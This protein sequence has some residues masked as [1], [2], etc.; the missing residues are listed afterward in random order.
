MT[1]RRSEAKYRRKDGT[2][3]PVELRTILLKDEKG[4]PCGM[5][6]IIRDITERKQAE[7]ALKRAHDE[8][9]QRVRERTAELAVANEQLQTIYDG[10]I[11]GLLITDIETKRFVRATTSTGSRS[12]R[13]SSFRPPSNSAASSH[14]RKT[15]SIASCRRRWPT[16]ASTARAKEY[17]SHWSSKAAGFASRCRIGEWASIQAGSANAVSVWKES[18]SGRDCL[19]GRAPSRTHR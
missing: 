10:V 17:G 7:E 5:W 12:G 2:V 13:R 8:L 11:E 4:Q 16:P 15:P 14:F 3:V 19:G 1:D 9:E 18:A 6:A